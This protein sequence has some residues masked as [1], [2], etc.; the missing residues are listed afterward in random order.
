MTLAIA[1]NF[2]QLN[3][4]DLSS[5][6]T[7]I[8]NLLQAG[9]IT[10]HEQQLCFDIHYPREPDDP[11]ELSEI[12]EIRLWFIRLDAQYPWLPF[13]LDWKAGELARYTAMLVPH[14]FSSKE[15]IQFNPEALEIFLMHKIFI[16]HD[17]MQ[18]QGIPSQS[19]LKSMGQMFGY[20]LED[21]FFEMF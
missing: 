2:N 7:A 4:L 10:A 3:T 21:T 1:L 19:R 8:E 16:L 6:Q 20:D 9:T 18:Q 5:V 14:Q 17:W 15:G 13:L 11:R 12:P